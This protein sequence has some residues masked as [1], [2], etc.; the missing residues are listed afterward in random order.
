MPTLQKFSRLD[1]QS[2]KPI[3]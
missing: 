1:S 3:G 2:I